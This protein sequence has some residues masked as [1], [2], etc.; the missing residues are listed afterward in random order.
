[1]SGGRFAC[2]SGAKPIAAL[3]E[4]TPPRPLTNGS[5]MSARKVGQLHGGAFGASTGFAVKL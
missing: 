4:P 1:M 2:S 3:P 5:S